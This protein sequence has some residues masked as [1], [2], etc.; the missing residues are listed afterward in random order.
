MIEPGPTLMLVILDGLG[1]RRVKK[2]GWKTPLEAAKKKN[3]DRMAKK[4]SLGFHYPLKPGLPIGSGIAHSL[5]F[6]CPVSA[7]PGRGVFEALGMGFD[8]KRGDLAFRVNFANLDADNIAV[9][10]RAGRAEDFLPEMTGELNKA[11]EENPFGKKIEMKSSYGYRGA[12]VV[13]DW[14]KPVNIPDLDPQLDG[15]AV[16][17]PKGGEDTKLATWIF[18]KAREVM[19]ESQYNEKRKELGVPV[20]N[21]LL[22][23]GAGLYDSGKSGLLGAK[24]LGIAKQHL[25][26]GSARYA[27]MYVIEEKEEEK[28]IPTALENLGKYDFIFV[29]FKKTDNA[30]HDGLVYEKKEAIEEVDKFLKPLL[31]E[32]DV[33]VA[34]TGDHATPC[35]LKTHSGDPVPLLFWGKHV[36]HDDQKSFGERQCLQGGIGRLR[37]IDIFRM[38]ANLAGRM[39]E[40]G[41]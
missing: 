10:R 22:L 31:K 33:A 15:H 30:G 3:M 20:A 25:Y 27:G 19:R 32:E 18:N 35:E 24:S 11:F 26:L 17:L 2:L 8:L 7:Y 39:P 40:V 34:I 4:G 38:L 13:R 29:H 21:G 16:E 14:K 9:D 1:D 41:K 5:L 36:P 37:A 28:K 12:V 23:R 6:G